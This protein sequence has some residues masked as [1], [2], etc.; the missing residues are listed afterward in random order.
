MPREFA[1]L[2]DPVSHSLSPAIHGAAFAAWGVNARY[3]LRR[4][5]RRRVPE[6][7]LEVAARGGGNVTLPH[8]ELVAKLVDEPTGAVVETGACNCF[9]PTATGVAGDNTDVGGF[10][11]ALGDQAGGLAGATVLMLGAGG[12]ARAVLHALQQVGVARVDIWNRTGSR[13]A[14]LTATSDENV[15][16]L[17]HLPDGGGYDLIVNATRLG[18]SNSDPLPI[19]LGGGVGRSVFDLVYSPSGTA[20]VRHA[21]S[22]G[23][24]AR[25]GRSMLVHQAALSLRHWFPD[26]EPSLSAM[27]A[28]V[29]RERS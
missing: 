6:A 8:K 19:D 27:F 28:A 26:R 25:D 2:G 5:D 11:L 3:V 20:W 18:L 4:V 9:W 12:A 7:L 21:E 23:V 13:A 22:L 10:L 29:G 14:A 16:A 15:V 1:L 17:D 24:P